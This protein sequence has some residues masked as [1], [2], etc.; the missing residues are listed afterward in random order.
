[1]ENYTFSA[2]RQL[3]FYVNIGGIQRL[4]RFGSRNGNGVSVFTTA[5]RSTAEAIRKH[6]L[7][8][9]GVVKEQVVV[10]PAADAAG[11]VAGKASLKSE[12]NAGR[13]TAQIPAADTTGVVA[14]AEPQA[15][16]IEAKNFT[17]AKSMLAKR[18]DIKYQDIKTPE[19][20]LQLAK[21]SGII[22]KY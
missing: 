11:V 8:L 6:S 19:Q 22:I 5:L 18:L 14:D 17:Q 1:M 4:V 12:G 9:R 13:P 2:D 10:K 20:L 3:M 21:E 15:E 7:Y 16:V